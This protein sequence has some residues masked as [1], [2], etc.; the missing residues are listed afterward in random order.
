[1]DT[2]PIQTIPIETPHAS[3]APIDAPPRGLGGFRSP[4]A[5]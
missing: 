2:P 1:M 4:V 5:I 3:R